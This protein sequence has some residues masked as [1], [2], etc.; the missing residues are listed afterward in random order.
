MKAEVVFVYSFPLAALTERRTEK[1]G[2]ERTFRV[3]RGA[4][5]SDNG[6][7]KGKGREKLIVM[8]V[9]RFTYGGV[10]WHGKLKEGGRTRENCLVNWMKA[11]TRRR[12][13]QGDNR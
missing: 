11:T 9:S 4:A 3:D 13:T 7:E 12:K 1:R 2:R 10:K 8:C 5:T 6:Q